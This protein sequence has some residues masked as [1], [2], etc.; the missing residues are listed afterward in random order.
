MRDGDFRESTQIIL[1]HDTVCTP[2]SRRQKQTKRGRTQPRAIALSS[3]CKSL[4]DT[5]HK[6]GKTNKPHKRGGDITREYPIPAQETHVQRYPW[7]VMIA[8]SSGHLLSLHFLSFPLLGQA[9]T[10]GRNQSAEKR[11]NRRRDEGVQ[12]PSRL[13]VHRW[14]LH[15]PNRIETRGGIPW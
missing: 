1:R 15:W 4:R 10:W 14:W 12:T 7:K 2:P 6:L 3:H 5:E 9:G 8:L 11:G 13:A